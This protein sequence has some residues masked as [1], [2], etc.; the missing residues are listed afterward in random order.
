MCFLET[1][2]ESELAELNQKLQ[3]A[4]TW[5][6]RRLKLLEQLAEEL[7]IPK[8]SRHSAIAYIEGVQALKKRVEELEDQLS[9]YCNGC[10]R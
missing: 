9:D 8:G 10:H 5:A 2:E 4:K 3:W 1:P 7:E 6:E